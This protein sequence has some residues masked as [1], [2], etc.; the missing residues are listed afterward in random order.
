MAA[1]FRNYVFIGKTSKGKLKTFERPKN[2]LLSFIPGG[3][4]YV[5]PDVQRESSQPASF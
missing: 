2:L 3:E 5:F 4:G 1:L